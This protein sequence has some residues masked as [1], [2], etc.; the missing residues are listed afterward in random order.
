MLTGVSFAFTSKSDRPPFWNGRGYG[1]KNYG[2]KVTFNCMNSLL[3]F[4]KI[5]PKVGEK[6]YKVLM[7]KPEGK[8][9]FDR[10]RRRWKD[11]S[12]MDLGEIGWE[13]DLIGSG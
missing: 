4:I 5:A 8:R 6:V 13:V 3:N 7:G 10:P 2:K 1:F 9:P 12:I 11:G